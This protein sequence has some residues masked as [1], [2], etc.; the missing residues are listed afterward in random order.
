MMPIQVAI[1]GAGGAVG[2]KLLAYLGGDTASCLRGVCRNEVTA[3][4]LRI[5]GFDVRCG[6]VTDVQAAQELLGD[7]DLV[8]N[9]AAASGNPGQARAQD[10]ALLR[11][12]SGLPGKRRFIH[13]SS[14]GVYGTCVTAGRNTFERPSPDWPY[15]RDKL[16]LERYL[17]R[18]M[19]S[20]AHECI[21][22]RMGH[23][24]GAGLWL[25]RA[26][27]EMM[28]EPEFRLPF[29]G[30]L[31][32]NAIHVRNV[33]AAVRTLIR[34]WAEPGLYNLFDAP[35]RTWRE[36][37]D[38]NSAAVHSLPVTGLEADPSERSA[39]YFRRCAASP[40]GRRLASEAMAW[41]G[42]LPGSLVSACPSVKDLGARLLVSL[43]SAPFARRVQFAYSGIMA[44]DDPRPNVPVRPWLVSD[45]AP[46]R[47]LSYSGELGPE[48][49]EALA[50]WY[51]RYR[52]PDS[53]LDWERPASEVGRS[54]SVDDPG[55]TLHL[56][57][58]R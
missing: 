40:L 1:V 17:T 24:Y 28:E 3:G 12:L 39:S 46:G 52:N 9:C 57:T 53:L 51:F 33:A 34:K 20:S 48:D 55:G 15:G 58:A 26:I 27:L 41:A 49:A 47:Q 50:R 56:Q 11:A 10:E 19:V 29:D 45:G 25:S 35:V 30:R 42:S 32:S 16:H 6:D 4:P 36:V 13:F 21:I 37:F 18:R 23:V 54:P 44:R 7:C 38:W 31:P 8:V 43:R 2:S 22:L 5:A 14:V